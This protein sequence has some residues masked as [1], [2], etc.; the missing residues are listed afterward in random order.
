MERIE[1]CYARYNY[2]GELFKFITRG[3]LYTIYM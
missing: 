1:G 3:I 2:T